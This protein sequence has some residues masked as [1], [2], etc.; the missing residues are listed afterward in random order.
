ML[1]RIR[2]K[3]DTWITQK[4]ENCV[5][6]RQ[7]GKALSGSLQKY[8]SYRIGNDRVICEIDDTNRIIH[9]IT[10]GHHSDIYSQMI[11][12]EDIIYAT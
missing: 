1:K 3:I 11:P 7:Y 12:E 9:I 5:T 2:K 10:I 6:P 4:I 8:W